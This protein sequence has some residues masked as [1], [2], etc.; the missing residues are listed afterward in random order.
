MRK[1]FKFLITFLFSF[2]S[3]FFIT[4][5]VFGATIFQ[6]DLNSYILNTS[7]QGYWDMAYS[8]FVNTNCL[9]GKCLKHTGTNSANSQVYGIGAGY[10]TGETDFWLR[11]HNCSGSSQDIFGVGASVAHNYCPFYLDSSCNLTTVS[12]TSVKTSIPLDTYVH[13]A[14]NWTPSTVSIQYNNETPVSA[15]ACA[16]LNYDRVWLG[17]RAS[18][19]QLDYVGFQGAL[20]GPTLTVDSPAI[21]SA[22]NDPT[23]TLD[24]TYSGFEIGDSLSLYFANVGLGGQTVYSDTYV[25][26]TASSGIFSIPFSTFNLFSNESWFLIPKLN[27]VLLDVSPSNYVIFYGYV[28]PDN[29][30]F[31]GGYT[32]EATCPGNCI[33]N[34]GSGLCQSTP[35]APNPTDYSFTDTDFGYFGNMFRDVVVY[36]FFPSQANL[37][38]QFTSIQT[39]ASN[40]IPFAYY[41]ALKTEFIAGSSALTTGAMPTI[42][43]TSPF[44]SETTMTFLDFGATKTLLGDTQWNLMRTI[45][46]YLLW[47]GAFL[48]VWETIHKGNTAKL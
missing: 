46:G 1:D 36:L 5:N 28:P 29:S 44:D 42:S 23:T 4:T 47:F 27:D 13:I 45:M 7:D 35:T 11:L 19:A 14:I 17:T 3:V 22:V 33:W 48:F 25:S 30:A 15:N 39:M 6:D 32:S 21:N 8:E 37:N 43:L 10:A 31:C 18:E 20:P 26:S 38:Y 12:S 24:L 34:V 9:E 2:C 41:Y 40:K 16:G